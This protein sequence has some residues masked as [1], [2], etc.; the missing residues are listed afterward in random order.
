MSSNALA[1]V[2]VAIV[3]ILGSAIAW[4]LVDA[5]KRYDRDFGDDDE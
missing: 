5:G 4:S 3:F 1:W 2:V